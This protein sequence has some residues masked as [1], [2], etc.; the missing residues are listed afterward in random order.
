[1]RFGV[2][3]GLPCGSLLLTKC[4]HFLL[5]TILLSDSVMLF[6]LLGMPSLCSLCQTWLIPQ[7]SA[8]ASPHW[9]L[10]FHLPRSTVPVS[11]VGPAVLE[12]NTQGPSVFSVPVCC[13]PSPGQVL[14]YVCWIQL[15]N[16]VIDPQHVLVKV[17]SD[18]VHAIQYPYL[19][20]NGSKPSHL[21]SS[22]WI[23]KYAT[24]LSLLTPPNTGR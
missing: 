12:L 23:A 17:T 18:W 21:Y 22:L 6:P 5:Q 4:P 13:L 2:G 10:F 9:Q 16:S 1:M 19:C 11:T 20:R 8:L 14:R 24:S 15:G 3:P 7:D